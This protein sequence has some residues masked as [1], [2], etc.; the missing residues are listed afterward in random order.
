MGYSDADQDG[1][2]P[3][4][5]PTSGYVLLAAGGAIWR[6]FK[7]QTAVTT[8]S[9][10]TEYMTLKAAALQCVWIGQNYAFVLGAVNVL[11]MNLG[12]DNRGA[13]KIAKYDAS[14]NRT[15]HIDIKYH[16]VW[17][18]I[19][20]KRLFTEYCPTS[21]MAVDIFT[22]Q[23]MIQLF[24]RFVHINGMKQLEAPQEIHDW[25]GV[26]TKTS[27]IIYSFGH[28]RRLISQKIN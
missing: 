3:N 24:H 21:E 19:T 4:S 13:I 23:L 2:R 18:H 9:A 26:L 22:K 15:R 12:I 25:G 11:Q 6:Q 14:G 10:V 20:E 5:K 8:S 16:L 7:K 28:P 1:R 27:I 17:D